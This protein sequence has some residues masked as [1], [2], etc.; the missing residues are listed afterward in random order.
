ML[1]LCYLLKGPWGV[2]ENKCQGVIQGAIGD[3]KIECCIMQ[4]MYM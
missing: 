4:W 1:W 3:L 2:S